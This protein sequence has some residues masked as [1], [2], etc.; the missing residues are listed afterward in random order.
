MQRGTSTRA[1]EHVLSVVALGFALGPMT[2]VVCCGSA[3]KP[4]DTSQEI[5][6][7]AG[8]ALSDIDCVVA[9]R[10]Q[11]ASEGAINRARR[12]VELG[13]C[14]DGETNSDCVLRHLRTEMSLWYDL[15][16]A[17][18]AAHGTLQAWQA[19]N[20][21]WRK[22]GARP[23]NWDDTVCVPV[24]IMTRTIVGLLNDAA[25]PV[26]DGWRALVLQVEKLCTLGVVMAEV[27]GAGQ[28][29]QQ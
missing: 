29:E 17:L 12:Q 24:G 25:V 6:V 8:S 9:A 23:T 1:V 11:E 26:P 7:A 19:A 4:V 28:E 3:Q 27:A 20:D 13:Q 5:L 22:S 10:T 16:A 15:T 21:G 18:E 14:T 2:S